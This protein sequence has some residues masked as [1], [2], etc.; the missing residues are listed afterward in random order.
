MSKPFKA[1]VAAIVFL[2][3]GTT[4]CTALAADAPASTDNA[5]LTTAL[6]PLA[7]LPQLMDT[8][9]SGKVSKAEFMGFMEAEFDFADENKDG[10]LDPT[11]LK[12]LVRRIT[13]PSTGIR[14]VRN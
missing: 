11:D 9:K 5:I 2:A 12:N 13:H 7:Q 1:I 14:K 10:E 6:T 8:D 3:S 4:I